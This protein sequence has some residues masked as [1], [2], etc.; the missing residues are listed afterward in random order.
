MQK[1]L[2]PWFSGCFRQLVMHFIVLWIVHCP[3][4]LSPQPQIVS[5]WRGLPVVVQTLEESRHVRR[6]LAGAGAAHPSPVTRC[7]EGGR[8]SQTLYGVSKT[9]F[10]ST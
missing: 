1:C 5:N 2:T 7:F 3:D 9:L 4:P 8:L 10:D 6:A